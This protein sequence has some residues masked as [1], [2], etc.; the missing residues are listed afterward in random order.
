[1][2]GKDTCFLLI[3][4]KTNGNRNSTE[5]AI[6]SNSYWT[7]YN[8]YKVVSLVKTIKHLLN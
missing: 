1:M 2:Y 7:T 8:N 3:V 4:D 6:G 5:S